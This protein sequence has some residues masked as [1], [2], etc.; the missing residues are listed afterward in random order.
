MLFT[1]EA[2]QAKQGDCLV[3]HYG[4]NDAPK[5]IVIDGGPGGIYQDFLKPRLLEIREA[6]TPDVP[7][8]LSM[9]MVSHMDDDHVNGVLD[10]TDEL[11]EAVDDNRPPVFDVQNMWFNTFDDI[12]GNLQIPRLSGL[13]RT[14]TV[15]DLVGIVPQ[16]VTLDRHISA[17]IASTGQGRR[18]R[19]DAEFLTVSVNSPFGPLGPG[20]PALVRGDVGDNS[21]DWGDG[22]SIRVLHPDHQRLTEMQ[23]KWDEDLKKAAQKGDDSIIFASLGK[24]DTSPFN[25]AS[26]VCL[27][28]FDGKRMLLTGD[29]RDDDIL[30]GLRRANLLD[31][32]DHIHVDILKIPH[33]GSDRNMSQHFFERVSA[34]HYIISGNGEYNNPDKS[35]LVMLSM[36][37]QGRDDFTIHLTNHEG[38]HELQKKL[39]EFIEDDRRR[40]RTYGFEFRKEDDLSLTVDLLDAIDY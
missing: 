6:L 28:E 2:L 24:R 35:T 26:I 33:H 27:V 21:I 38:E 3:L 10:L 8:P 25:L 9:V 37:T 12:V 29:A 16:F 22:L 39:D 32:D 18:L 1:L 5:I 31:G 4:P 34:D 36:A 7:L 40:G 11:C 13:G 23:D 15:A 20:K 14:A 19:D 17:V 30:D